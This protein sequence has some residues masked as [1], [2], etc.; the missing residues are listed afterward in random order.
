MTTA[1]AYEFV[2]DADRDYPW[3]VV[4]PGEVAYFSG[5]APDGDWSPITAAP[6]PAPESEGPAPADEGSGNPAANEG[7]GEATDELKRPGKAA[8]AADWVAYAKTEGTFPGD[9]DTA[10]RKAIVDHYTAGSDE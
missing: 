9:P 2:G 3:G 7:G 5:R 8:S 6:A 4:H 10:T 1:V